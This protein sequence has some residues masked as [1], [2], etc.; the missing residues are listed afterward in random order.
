[1]RILIGN[2]QE[3][4]VT[5]KI[6][7]IINKVGTETAGCFNISDNTEVSITFVNNEE[8]QELNRIYRNIDC[9]TDVLSFAFDEYGA[10]EPSFA[11]ISDIHL[12]GEVIISFERAETQAQEYGHSL[13]REIGYLVIHGLLHLL[14]FDHM[15]DEESIKMREY[16]ERILSSVDLSR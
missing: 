7:E 12:L 3:R 14:G 8:I 13:E 10:E 15:Q 16:E 9:P 2:Q 4:I 1:M 11:S 6:E 5:D